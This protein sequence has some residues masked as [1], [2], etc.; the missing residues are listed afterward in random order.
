MKFQPLLYPAPHL[1]DHTYTHSEEYVKL[2]ASALADLLSM[3]SRGDAYLIVTDFMFNLLTLCDCTEPQP[4]I[5]FIYRD[6]VKLLINPSKY[7][8]HVDWLTK[9]KDK[10]FNEINCCTEFAFISDW[11]SEVNVL[12]RLQQAYGNHAKP[13]I[14][15]ICQEE[16]LSLCANNQNN[17]ICVKCCLNSP[18]NSI[19]LINGI[20]SDLALDSGFEWIHPSNN[21]RI[22][23]RIQHIKKNFRV[24]GGFRLEPPYKD[25]HYKIHFPNGYS[26]PFSIND[27]P[28]PERYLEEL[29]RGIDMP[30]DVL[31]AALFTGLPPILK[32][33]LDIAR[34]ELDSQC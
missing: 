9:Y 34:D 15:I 3:V 2:I 32:C 11:A 1:I 19:P 20:I 10:N 7:I 27:D 29:S 16:L 17:E 6:L 8:L 24:V 21:K 22:R 23:I 13:F 31:K 18:D 12:V 5:S 28:V 4:F 33:K 26:W 14:G 25:S 30:K